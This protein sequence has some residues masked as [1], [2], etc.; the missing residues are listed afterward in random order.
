[1]KEHK[2]IL[3]FIFGILFA[4]VL[5]LIDELVTV[6]ATWMEWLKIIP[7]RHI[8]KGN[9]EMQDLYDGEEAVSTAA[10]DFQMPEPDEE[11]Y[12]NEE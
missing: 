3:L 8:A 6:I 12:E 5:P 9:K 4:S 10:I 7:S 2:T 1:M 11:Y